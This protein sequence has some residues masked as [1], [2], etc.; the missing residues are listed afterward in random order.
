MPPGPRHPDRPDADQREGPS[1]RPSA[2]AAASATWAQRSSPSAKSASRAGAASRP[3]RAVIASRACARSCGGSGVCQPSA[4]ARSASA[5]RVR[6]ASWRVT[7]PTLPSERGRP[8]PQ[9]A[10]S[11]QGSPAKRPAA[12]ARTHQVRHAHTVEMAREG[13][14][15]NVIQRQPGNADLGVNSIYLQGID[16]AGSGGQRWRLPR[17]R[18]RVVIRPGSLGGIVP[19]AETS[20]AGPALIWAPGLA[21]RADEVHDRV[22]G[23]ATPHS[24]TEDRPLRVLIAEDHVLLREGLARLIASCAGASPPARPTGGS[25]PHPQLLKL[26]RAQPA[27]KVS[28]SGPPQPA[29]G[30]VLDGAKPR[31]RSGLSTKKSPATE[32][33]CNSFSGGAFVVR[34]GAAAEA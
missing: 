8:S 15:Q 24:I 30:A 20:R 13:L 29:E 10:A 17:H 9:A 21:G 12:P 7:G 19:L 5:E 32:A 14:P 6:R 31:Q 23:A 11:A 4:F 1:A 26:W 18:P 2:A 25:S 22:V 34:E 16:N 28:E 27:S 33:L 3:S